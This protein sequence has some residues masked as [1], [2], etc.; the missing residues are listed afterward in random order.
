MQNN[1]DKY[2][3]LDLNKIYEYMELPDRISGRCDHCGNARFKT[4]VGN[5]QY[6]RKCVNCGLTKNL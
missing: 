6:L 2:A 3:N 1:E 4:K 5:G